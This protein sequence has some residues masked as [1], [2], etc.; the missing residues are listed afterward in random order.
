MELPVLLIFS[1]FFFSG[2][3]EKT[4]PVYFF[5]GLFALHYSQRIFVFP[6]LLRGRKKQMPLLIVL[7]AIGFNLFNGFF[8]GYWF[9]YLNRY[10]YDTSWFSDWRFITGITLF[11][12]GMYLNIASD[13]RLIHLRK[14][15]N[16]GYYIPYGGW[17]TYVSSPN[18]LGE[19]IEWTGW[20][21]MSWCLPTLAFAV[22]TLANLIPRALDHHKWYKQTF[23]EYPI[24]RNAVFPFLL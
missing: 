15:G 10:H 13:Q 3:A 7:L 14:K 18:L 23:P 21:L 16:G 11:I 22:W 19:I 12:S 20:A 24:N 1:Y 5:Y 8:N 17:F 6:L 9:G 2:N 4:L